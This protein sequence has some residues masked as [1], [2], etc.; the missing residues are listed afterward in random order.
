MSQPRNNG[1]RQRLP[2]DAV[3]Q[4]ATHGRQL[5]RTRAAANPPEIETPTV[6]ARATPANFGSAPSASSMGR[7]A[8]IPREYLRPPPFANADSP[9][10]RSFAA[11]GRAPGVNPGTTGEGRF[12]TER[13]EFID[14]MIRYTEGSA[15][16]ASHRDITDPGQPSAGPST[17]P[18]GSY[19]YGNLD[20]R[21]LRVSGGGSRTRFS[22]FLEQTENSGSQSS[23]LTSRHDPPW[24]AR[25]RMLPPSHRDSAFDGSNS[26]EFARRLQQT[27]VSPIDLD[28]S[29]DGPVAN[30][31]VHPESDRLV[32][33]EIDELAH[34]EM[35][36]LRQAAH[37]GAIL[38]QARHQLRMRE[39][40][41][42][43]FT[44]LPMGSLEDPECP[45]CFDEYDE[46]VHSAVRLDKVSCDHVFGRSCIQEWV[47]SQMSN[48]DRC[49]ACRRSI[50]GALA[51]AG[52]SSLRAARHLD[53]AGPAARSA[54]RATRGDAVVQLSQQVH[55]P[56]QRNSA[57]GFSE[58]QR[59]SL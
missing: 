44:S 10:G 39:A 56:L 2:P 21:T 57:L 31:R 23:D 50:L 47:Q 11:Q 7:I 3:S 29:F 1:R 43:H 12:H 35:E 15:P 34:L 58:P 59:M 17:T 4:G 22:T 32:R 8:P 30:P 27:T 9:H 42:E 45:I 14:M 33:S 20:P 24:P 25:P 40:R 28:L 53:L 46:S 19:I 6:P 18:Y 41:I 37:R 5:V 52:S 36:Q 48:A 51:M 49:P 16:R 55:N 54:P 13:Q 38:S 26:R